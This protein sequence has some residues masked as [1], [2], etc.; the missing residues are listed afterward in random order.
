MRP[1]VK[2]ARPFSAA[3]RRPAPGNLPGALCSSQRRQDPLDEEPSVE[4]LPAGD[5]GLVARTSVGVVFRTG[6]QSRGL[7]P[8][9]V[10][11]RMEVDFASV[12]SGKIEYVKRVRIKSSRVARGA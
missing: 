5:V 6:V 10:A 2:L 7:Q 9:L 3:A 11:S 4:F 8:Q 12:G 1:T